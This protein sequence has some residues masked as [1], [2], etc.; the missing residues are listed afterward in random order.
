MLIP[1]EQIVAF[2]DF[3]IEITCFFLFLNLFFFL[4][5]ISKSKIHLNG[6][7]IFLIDRVTETC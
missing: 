4:Q 7:M 2:N 3:L 5:A 1:N 6:N